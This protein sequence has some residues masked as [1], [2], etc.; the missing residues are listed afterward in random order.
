MQAYVVTFDAVGLPTFPPLTTIYSKRNWLT[1]HPQATILT[2][3]PNVVRLGAC[4]SDQQQQQQQQHLEPCE[5]GG[6]IV[7][8]VPIS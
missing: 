6:L 4:M 3:L 7:R 2:L 8:Y 1:S 5:N